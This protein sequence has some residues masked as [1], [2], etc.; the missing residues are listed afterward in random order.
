LFVGNLAPWKGVATLT[1]ALSNLVEH[2]ER[3]RLVMYG[4]GPLADQLRQEAERLPIHLAGFKGK[5]AVARAYA[6]ADMFVLPSLREQWGLVV[7]EALSAGL[8]VVV[9]EAVGCGEDLVQEGV[10]GLRFRTG[11]ADAL[12]D[13]MRLLLRD[14]ELCARLGVGGK[15][16]MQ[17]WSM[18]TYVASMLEALDQAT[19]EEA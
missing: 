8:P 13:Q 5:E 16:R 4:E 10:T 3:V 11:D 18:E 9:S 14:S 2:G 17:T 12:A 1:A 15:K 7:N 6:A 19:R